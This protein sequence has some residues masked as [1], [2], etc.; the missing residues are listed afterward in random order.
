MEGIVHGECAEGK[1][2]KMVLQIRVSGGRDWAQTAE[3]GRWGHL[4]CA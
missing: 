3:S 1:G 4:V 2:S